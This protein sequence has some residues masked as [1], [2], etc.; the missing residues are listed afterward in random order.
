MIVQV[1]SSAVTLNPSAWSPAIMMRESRL[2]SAPVSLV[3]PSAS[4]ART[5]ARLVMLLEPGRSTT[6]WTGWVNGVMGKGSAKGMRLKRVTKDVDHA[7]LF[8]YAR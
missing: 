1:D 2:K 3:V 4:A 7:K 6:P 5:S 8:L